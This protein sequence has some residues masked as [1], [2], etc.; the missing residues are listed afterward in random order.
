MRPA[1][2][3]KTSPPARH[4]ISGLGPFTLRTVTGMAWNWHGFFADWQRH[5]ASAGMVGSKLWPCP[6][7]GLWAWE[8]PACGPR[9]YV[10][11]GIHGDEPAGPMAMLEL[12]KAGFFSSHSCHWLL[13]PAINPAGLASGRRENPSGMDL[14]RDYLLRSSGEVSAHAAWLASRPPPDLFLSLHEDW[15]TDGFYFYEINQGMDQPA[16][17][18]AI[19]DAVAPWFPPQAGPDIDGHAPRT[20]GWIYHRAEAD[21]PTGWPEAIFLAKHGC[22][23]SFTFESPSQAGLSKRTAALAAALTAALRHFLYSQDAWPVSGDA[24][25]PCPPGR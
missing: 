21:V 10:S 6:E 14:N 24:A 3:H 25:D 11:A 1:N 23:L 7:G 4:L 19:L 17:A 22:P 13:C 5:A 8:R 20:P 18:Q 2:Y 16:R 15:E 12:L 9:I